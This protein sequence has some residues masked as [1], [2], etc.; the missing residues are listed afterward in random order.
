MYAYR[1]THPPVVSLQPFGARGYTVTYR[2]YDENLLNSLRTFQDS[3][4]PS[5]MSRL[6]VG[7]G[8][9]ELQMH[10]FPRSEILHS[11]FA[12]PPRYGL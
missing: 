10:V 11:I 6:E 1:S 12:R 8:P 2:S 5:W 3:L 7:S 4:G 9:H